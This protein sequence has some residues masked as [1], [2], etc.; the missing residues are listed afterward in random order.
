MI[1]KDSLTLPSLSGIPLGWATIRGW[2]RNQCGINYIM[3]G[4]TTAGTPAGATVGAW[5]VS[6][7]A[8]STNQQDAATGSENVLVLD[9][10][11]AGPGSAA[12]I[13]TDAQFGQGGSTWNWNLPP[14]Q[15]G[16]AVLSS[17]RLLALPSFPP[18]AKQAWFCTHVL[19]HEL[20]H[21]LLRTYHCADYNYGAED[22]NCVFVRTV[23]TANWG[24]D[25]SPSNTIFVNIRGAKRQINSPWHSLI[26]INNMREQLGL[27]HL[28]EW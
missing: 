13:D 28:N 9:Y 7:N 10:T 19:T 5:P 4:A 6:Y 17:T 11:G 14:N 1:W 2:F 20:T 12:N 21:G 16:L 18:G 8:L 27:P 26:E 23:T 15:P 3:Q 25:L 22:P 24:A